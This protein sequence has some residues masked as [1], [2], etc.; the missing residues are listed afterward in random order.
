MLGEWYAY[1]GQALVAIL[2]GILLV[3]IRTRYYWE[4]D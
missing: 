4:E 3:W 1:W 2:F